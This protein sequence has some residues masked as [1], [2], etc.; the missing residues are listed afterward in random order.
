MKFRKLTIDN[1]KSFQF[2]TEIV[3][4]V[5]LKP[6]KTRLQTWFANQDGDIR[7]AFFVEV[8]RLKVD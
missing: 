8:K 5:E 4:P 2:S 3:F 6:G 7:G 1:Y